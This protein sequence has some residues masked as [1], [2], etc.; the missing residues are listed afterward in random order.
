MVIN[1]KVTKVAK[2]NN[3][4]SYIKANKVAKSSNPRKDRGKTQRIYLLK[5]HNHLEEVAMIG[6]T[7]GETGGD[8][9]DLSD[10]GSGYSYTSASSSTA[11]SFEEMPTVIT[12]E[13]EEFER[14]FDLCGTTGNV[15]TVSIRDKP[16]CSCP[17]HVQRWNRCK[18]IFFILVRVMKVD[19]NNEDKLEYTENELKE[20]FNNIPDQIDVQSG[21]TADAKLI[22]KY[23]N[24]RTDVDGTIMKHKISADSRCPVCLDL[25][26]DSKE[27][28][29]HCKYGCGSVVH[30]E[31]ATMYNSHRIKTGYSAICFVCQ[32]NWMPDKSSNSLNNDQYLNLNK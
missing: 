20:M 4:R 5:I 6:V 30:D 3:I 23:S 28:T 1:P 19:S 32:K 18:H 13:K 8:I 29:S 14:K 12:Q 2:D 15:Y 24:L 17:D 25:F 26:K 7:G 16:T 10:S 27:H 21:V 11:E 31:C 9:V 22:S